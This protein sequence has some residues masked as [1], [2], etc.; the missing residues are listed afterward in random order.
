MN[1][2]NC[3]LIDGYIARREIESYVAEYFQYGMF[4]TELE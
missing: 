1:E 4:Q 2:C 3:F